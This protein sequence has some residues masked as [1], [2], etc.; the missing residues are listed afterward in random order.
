MRVS[1]QNGL[2]CKKKLIDM[3]GILFRYAMA[4]T[5]TVHG[6]SPLLLPSTR[7]TTK[8][9]SAARIGKVAGLLKC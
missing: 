2:C 6:S 1:K 8:E 9:I 4:L 5:P 3:K 7:Q